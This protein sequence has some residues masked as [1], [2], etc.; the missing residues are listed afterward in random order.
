MRTDRLLTVCP[1]C[2]M[3]HPGWGCIH[4]AAGVVHPGWWIS[5]MHPP[6]PVN[7]MT[8][9]CENITFPALLPYVVGKNEMSGW[10]TPRFQI[11]SIS[12]RFWEILAKKY[13]DAPTSD[14]S[15][16]LHWKWSFFSWTLLIH[17]SWAPAEHKIDAQQSVRRCHC[18]SPQTSIFISTQLY[19]RTLVALFERVKSGHQILT[20]SEIAR[21]IKYCEGFTVMALGC[22]LLGTRDVVLEMRPEVFMSMPPVSAKNSDK[23]FWIW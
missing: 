17:N 14:K 8:H 18:R 3:V 21:T 11:I 5:W 2:R 13:V 10:Y 1:C 20:L 15:W 19:I 9:G 22:E 4:A 7:R 16:I 12:C 23:F 6:P